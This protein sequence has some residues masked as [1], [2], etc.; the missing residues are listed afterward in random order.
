MDQEFKTPTLISSWAMPV[1]FILLFSTFIPSYAMIY[2]AS[3]YIGI[4][5]TDFS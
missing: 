4:N 2:L 5:F 1:D 3:K